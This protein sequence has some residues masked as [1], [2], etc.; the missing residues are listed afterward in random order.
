M[1]DAGVEPTS[2]RLDVEWFLWLKFT[3]MW[4]KNVKI[5]P[6]LQIHTRNKPKEMLQPFKRFIYACLFMT[7]AL[8]SQQTNKNM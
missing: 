5:S 2:L 7:C 1:I 8:E 3:V 4:E 6:K